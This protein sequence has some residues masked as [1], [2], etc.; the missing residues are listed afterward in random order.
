MLLSDVVRSYLRVDRIS[1]KPDDIYIDI[2]ISNQTM[3]AKL[4]SE[5]ERDGVPANNLCVVVQE[6]IAQ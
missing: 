3:P 2:T 5:Y 1:M 4:V 6:P